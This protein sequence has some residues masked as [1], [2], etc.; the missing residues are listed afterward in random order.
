MDPSWRMRHAA[1]HD[2]SQGVEEKIWADDYLLH[3]QAS[4][5][6]YGFARFGFMRTERFLI[7]R[8]VARY[9]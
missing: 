1:G 5:S 9:E 4:L 8:V 7:T 3:L 2:V 6:A